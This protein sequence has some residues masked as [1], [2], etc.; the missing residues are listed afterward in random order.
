[1]RINQ[2]GLGMWMGRDR[3]NSDRG[4]EGKGEKF[5]IRGEGTGGVDGVEST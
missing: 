1:M 5:L 4:V 3:M 2:M